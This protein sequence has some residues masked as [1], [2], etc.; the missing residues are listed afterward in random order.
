MADVQDL[1][2]LI[3]DPSH[4]P[5]PGEVHHVRQ[6]EQRA[7]GRAEPDAAARRRLPV[8]HLLHAGDQLQPGQLRLRGSSSRSPARP[9]LRTTPR[10]LADERLVLNI[11]SKGHLIFNGQVLTADEAT[12]KIKLE[13]QIARPNIKALKGKVEP[14]EALP[15]RVVIRADR[16][17]PFSALFS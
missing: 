10:K 11:D 13:A 8:D 3:D 5:R 12:Q 17:T 1:H 7:P 4:R 15:A 2:R 9:A 6:H 14:G 16:D